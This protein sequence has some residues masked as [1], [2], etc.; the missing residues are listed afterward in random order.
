VHWIA[1]FIPAIAQFSDQFSWLRW[2]VVG[3][4]FGLVSAVTFFFA[5]EERPRWYAAL[6][7]GITAGLVNVGASALLSLYLAL[8]PS[9]GAWG[10]AAGVFATLL[11]LWLLALGL[12][13]GA[14]VAFVL[15]ARWRARW[16]AAHPKFPLRRAQGR[17]SARRS[18]RG[19]ERR[20]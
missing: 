7:G 1:R 20:R 6:A 5:T 17:G 11:W 16:R 14:V 13:V 19:R 12:L 2:P 10:A 8:A 18:R 4:V 3:V 9:M 15:D